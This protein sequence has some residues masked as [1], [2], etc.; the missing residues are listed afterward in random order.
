MSKEYDETKV[1]PAISAPHEPKKTD[2]LKVQN[3]LLR[4]EFKINFDDAKYAV[5][6]IKTQP[7]KTGQRPSKLRNFLKS[8]P[9]IGG[10]LVR[11]FTPKREAYKKLQSQA[12]YSSEAKNKAH[13]NNKHTEE[14]DSRLKKVMLNK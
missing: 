4:R 5:K 9:V 3:V 2:G 8:I 11:V 14:I 6:V 10:F 7:A 12:G 13:I 1:K